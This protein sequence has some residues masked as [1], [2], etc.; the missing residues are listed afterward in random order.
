METKKLDG[1]KFPCRHSFPR[2]PYRPPLSPSVTI[3]PK[4]VKNGGSS[5][6]KTALFSPLTCGACK[7]KMFSVFGFRLI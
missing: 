6:G 1:L 7:I 3:T 5:P 2:G 4:A